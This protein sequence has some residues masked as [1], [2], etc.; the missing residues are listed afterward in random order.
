MRLELRET[1]S[2]TQKAFLFDA[3][4][5]RLIP[6]VPQMTQPELRQPASQLMRESL[7][8]AAR[9]VAWQ[10]VFLALILILWVS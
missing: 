4:S 1:L 7:A 5:A 9:S 6:R 10:S 3:A 8:V 2:E